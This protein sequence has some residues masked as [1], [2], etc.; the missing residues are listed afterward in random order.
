MSSL[1]CLGELGVQDARCE[2]RVGEERH[3]IGGCWLRGA[4]PGVA[5]APPCPPQAT[6]L[7]ASGVKSKSRLWLAHDNCLS[8]ASLEVFSAVKN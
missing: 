6:V 3:P 1:G 4:L 2:I 8:S 7:H 5:P